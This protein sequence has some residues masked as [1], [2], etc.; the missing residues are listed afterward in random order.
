MYSSCD[1][2]N[3][4]MFIHTS[5][6]VILSQASINLITAVTIVQN[7]KCTAICCLVIFKKIKL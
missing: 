4:T 3:K 1:K 5:L 7:Q 6:H 2:D